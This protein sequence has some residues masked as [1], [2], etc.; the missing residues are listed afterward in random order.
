M[1]HSLKTCQ[2]L[3]CML[4]IAALAKADTQAYSGSIYSGNTI[5][6]DKQVMIIYLSSS[7]NGIVADY[8]G[9]LLSVANNSCES[10]DYFKLCLDNIEMDYVTRKKKIAIRAFSTVPEITITRTASKT[11]LIVGEEAIMTVKISNTGGIAR[12]TVFS[13]EF[14]ETFEVYDV[15]DAELKGNTVYWSGEI[16]RSGS[17]ELSFKL[18]PKD[19]YKGGL[20][21]KLDYFDGYSMQSAQSS[22]ISLEATHFFKL[23]AR[24]GKTEAYVGQLNNLTVNISNRGNS[25]VNATLEFTFDEGTELMTLPGN[26]IRTAKNSYRWNGELRKRNLSNNRIFSKALFFE[27]KT[28]R[29]GA[30]DTTITAQYTD[31]STYEKVRLPDERKTISVTDKGLMARSSLS[32]KIIEPG[33]RHT[34]K[35][36]VQNLNPYSD[37]RD[38]RVYVQTG[39]AYLP[40]LEYGSFKAGEQKQ[41]IQKDIFAPE[42]NTTTGYALNLN[43]TYKLAGESF[44][45]TFKDTVS[46]VPPKDLTITQNPSKS[47]VE[48]GETFQFTVLLQNNRATGLGNIKA[49]DTP[50]PEFSVSGPATAIISLSP[51][52]TATAYTYSITAPRVNAKKEFTI[53]TSAQYSD[54]YN[55]EVFAKFNTYNYSKE[56]AI[57]VNPPDFP[58]AATAAMKESDVYMGG[59]YDV[60][61]VIRNGHSSLTMTEPA[62]YFPLQPEFDTIESTNHSLPSIDPGETVYISSMHKVRPKLNSSQ[63]IKGAYLTFKDKYGTLYGYNLSDVPVTVKNSFLSGPAIILNKTAP[64]Q[65]NDTDQVQIRIRVLNT[66]DS[67]AL[68]DVAD[69]QQAFSTVVKPG[70]E[71]VHQYSTILTEEGTQSL[72]AATANYT[73][74]GRNLHTASETATVKITKKP[75]V[76]VELT[77]PEKANTADGFDVKLKIKSTVT[78]PLQVTV[79][80][81]AREWHIDNFTGQKELTYH[82]QLPTGQH[83]LGPATATY[84][85]R[86]HTYSTETGTATITVTEKELVTIAK[87]ASK[88]TIRPKQEI[89]VT[90]SLKN[91]QEEPVTG[92]VTD[93]DKNWEIDLAPNEARN[94]TYKTKPD[95]PA[96]KPATITVTYKNAT[97]T[98]SSEEVQMNI[99][100]RK[101]KDNATNTTAAPEAEAAQDDGIFKKIINAVIKV[102][103]WQRKPE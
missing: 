84:N 81:R 50:P 82:T 20:K 27:F 17:K 72:P 44:S 58:V 74:E 96:L 57:T 41:V 23:E 1:R 69:G 21:A 55:D 11:D 64:E 68:V 39:L 30:I 88:T 33:Q 52:A 38:V 28:N 18:R 75:L 12:R 40:Y 47:T 99:T 9:K 56:Q 100:G 60:N 59:A 90:L 34:L 45:Y 92:T 49:Y 80:D 85:H 2:W 16:A 101:L 3:L 54:Q 97:Y 89:Q 14:P 94:I 71:A 35:V 95:Q 63:K 62:L 13:D 65:A 46:V 76:Q 31:L 6:V 8:S 29:I 19:A 15:E 42:A 25:T 78:E 86:N 73:Y 37:I 83:T 36:W 24:L 10:T 70:T 26:L 48:S 61:Y 5:T 43:V 32:D 77:A 102:L 91:Q 103:T 51:G 67:T 98:F 79:T 22:E 53:K 66:G 93:S 4:A 7:Q 87:T